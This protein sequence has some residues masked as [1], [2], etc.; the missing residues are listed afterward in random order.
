VHNSQETWKKLEQV[1]N[2]I[3]LGFLRKEDVSLSYST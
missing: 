3:E 1:Q 2:L